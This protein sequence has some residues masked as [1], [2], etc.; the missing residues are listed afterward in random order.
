MGANI[1]KDIIAGLSD[2]VGGRSGVYEKSLMEGRSLALKEMQVEAKT[3]GANAVVG[4]R[5]DYS[6][7]S[8]Q[9]C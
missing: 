8:A 3:I 7:V 1:F 2:I 6:S 4:V 5:V 9:K